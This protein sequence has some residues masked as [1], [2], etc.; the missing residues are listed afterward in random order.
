MCI[1]E[2]QYNNL[3]K[4]VANLEEE[5]CCEKCLKELKE[6]TIDTSKSVVLEVSK[7]LVGE[8]HRMLTDFE[9]MFKE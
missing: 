8:Y 1:T 2:E 6:L 4:R 7:I 3:E 9:D 5:Y